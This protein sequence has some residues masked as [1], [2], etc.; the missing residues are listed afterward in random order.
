VNNCLSRI[1]KLKFDINFNGH[2]KQTHGKGSCSLTSYDEKTQEIIE[3]S[4][5]Y[6][7]LAVKERDQR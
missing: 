2:S 4:H 1:I 6:R 5:Q 7:I 3:E